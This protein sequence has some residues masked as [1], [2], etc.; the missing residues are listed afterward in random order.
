[1]VFGAGVGVALHLIRDVGN[2]PGLPLF[3]PLTT[4]NV[5][6]PYGCYAAAIVLFAV[7]ATVRCIRLVRTP[8]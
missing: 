8:G 5:I 6:T 4:A 1:V 3:W 7:I 2:G